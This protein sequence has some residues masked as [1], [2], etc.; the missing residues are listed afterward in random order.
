VSDDPLFN[1]DDETAFISLI[2]EHLGKGAATKRGIS[3][4]EYVSLARERWKACATDAV[5]AIKLLA[6]P[7]VQ[8]EIVPELP[9]GWNTNEP[10]CELIAAID[11][12]GDLVNAPPDYVPPSY[13][14]VLRFVVP[15]GSPSDVVVPNPAEPA[16][17]IVGFMDVLGFEA[18]LNELG[19]DEMYRRYNELLKTA[20]WPQSEARPWSG[21]IALVQGE[22]M[23]GLMHLPVQTA[24]FS[25]SLLLWVHYHPRHVPFFLDRCAKVFCQALALGIPIRGTISIGSAVLDKGR[26][27]YLG[28]PLIEAVRLENKLN[29]IGVALGASWQCETRRAP[30]P[31]DRVF[32]YEPPL[33]DAGS[34]L[35]SGLVL[36]WPRMWRETKQDSAIDHL[37][38]LCRPALSQ[39][40]KDRYIAAVRYVEYSNANQNWFLPPGAKRLTPQDISPR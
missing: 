10:F 15:A 7:L 19:L 28:T 36:D 32:V 25:D 31:P 21:E 11:S 1:P 14:D 16:E 22:P 35:F 12:K 27:I 37:L 4:R 2:K 13:P 40:L 6:D 20:L 34:P 30:V 26:G 17:Y 9:S 39:E 3:P 18:L 24:Y 8:P 33:K 5:Y 23:L 29:W 38:R